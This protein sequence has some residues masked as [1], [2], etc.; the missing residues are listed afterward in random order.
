VN[1]V[2]VHL[3]HQLS[4]A[5]RLLQIVLEQNESIREQDVEGVLARLSDVQQEMV[6]RIRLEQQRDQLLANAAAGLG[7]T[8]DEV[9]LEDMLRLVPAADA[10]RA[11]AMSA[12]LRGV[13]AEV[14]RVHEQNRLLIRQ[15]LSFLDHLLR[16]L[17]GTP[18]G[19]YSYGGAQGSS[20][21]INNL[22]DMR[23]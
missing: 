2:I 5:R 4:S 20:P 8:P 10:A 14:S 22:I 1:P 15:E 3:E 23:V 11:R 19:G 17:S 7:C 21:Q 12:E 6:K 13:L 18:E 9:T 16:V